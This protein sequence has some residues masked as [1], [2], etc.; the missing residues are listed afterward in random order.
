MD[1]VD[2]TTIRILDGFEVEFTF[3]GGFVRRI[4]L[5]PCIRGPIFQPLRDDPAVSRSAFVDP[6][7]G[8]ISWPNGADVDTHVLRYDLRPASWDLVD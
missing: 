6:E 3:S 5:D 1:L 8:V 2:V 4:D 7:A